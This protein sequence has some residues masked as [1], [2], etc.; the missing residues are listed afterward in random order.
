MEK[1]NLVI[2]G[3]YDCGIFTM[4]AVKLNRNE[5][6]L[7]IFLTAEQTNLAIEY[8][9]AFEPIM[10]LLNILLESGFTINQTI[11]IINGD[12]SEEQMQFLQDF[13]KIDEGWNEEVQ[14]INLSFSDNENPDNSNIEMESTGDGYTFTIY[15]EANDQTP[16]ELMDNL[17]FILA[18]N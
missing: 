7:P 1:I 17:K 6:S 15:T 5:R 13:N 2:E 11:E 8:D 9:D 16:S 3:D 18:Q 10:G 14:P 4:F 12:D